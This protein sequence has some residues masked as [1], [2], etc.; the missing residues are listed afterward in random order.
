MNIH[1]LCHPVGGRQQSGGTG[2]GQS[3]RGGEAAVTAGQPRTAADEA[4][5]RPWRTP[6]RG[7]PTRPGQRRICKYIHLY[8]YILNVIWK[9]PS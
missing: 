4:A 1:Y 2:G 9:E 3:D 6:P 5:G 7:P 8:Y